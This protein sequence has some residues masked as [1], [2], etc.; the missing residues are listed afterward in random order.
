MGIVTDE[1]RLDWDKPV[2]QCLPQ[3]QMY[4][5]VATERMTPR[6]LIS[7]RVGMAGHDLVWHTSDF[8]REDLLRRLRFLQPNPAFCR[9]YNYNT[10]L[11]MTARNP[12]AKVSGHACTGYS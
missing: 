4:D 9:R 2:G 8:S 1:G 12:A 3:F 10:L 7:Q 11:L 5:P 6:D